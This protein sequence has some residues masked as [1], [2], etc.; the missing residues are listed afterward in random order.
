MSFI[1]IRLI[2]WYNN[3]NNC[4]HAKNI[5]NKWWIMITM[6]MMIIMITIT[7]C[8]C[9]FSI[10][11][12]LFYVEKIIVISK[13]SFKGMVSLLLVVFFFF[14]VVYWWHEILFYYLRYYF[15]LVVYSKFIYFLNAKMKNKHKHTT[16]A[17]TEKSLFK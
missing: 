8:A 10:Y 13:F 17:A 14:L 7:I 6:M 11:I 9:K 4:N 1:F 16:H 2:I 12:L 3:K 5:N 15:M